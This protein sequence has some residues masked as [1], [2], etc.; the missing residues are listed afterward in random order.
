MAPLLKDFDIYHLLELYYK[1]TLDF[2]DVITQG[3]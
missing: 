3:H 2:Y 1:K